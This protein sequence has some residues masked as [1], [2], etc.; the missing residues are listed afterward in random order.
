DGIK[1]YRSGGWILVRPSGTEPI[2]RVF[3][4]AQSAGAA[5]ALASE[6]VRGVEE[7]LGKASG[8]VAA[9]TAS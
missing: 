9:S 3:A 1:V 5:E 2:V 7:A 4:E 8:T 6:G